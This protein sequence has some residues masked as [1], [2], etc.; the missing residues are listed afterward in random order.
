MAHQF[1]HRSHR[2]SSHHG[3]LQFFD[4]GV[5]VIKEEYDTY[6]YLL[7]K[8]TARM[9][10]GEYPIFVTAGD[11]RQKLTHIMHNQYLTHCF[12]DLCQVEGSLVTFGFNFGAQDEHII[13]AIN[14][15]AKRSPEEKLWSIYI[16]VYSEDDKKRIEQISGK[17]KC[18]VRTYDAKTVKVWG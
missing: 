9:D 11:G 6:N 8:I 3:A 7:Q 2:R 10:K 18:K 1:L 5:S 16:G 13:D 4:D 15:A 17:F 12:N 14:K